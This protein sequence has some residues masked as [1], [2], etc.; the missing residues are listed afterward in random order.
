MHYYL[1]VRQMM[2]SL[3]VLD[4]I[5]DKA[6]RYAEARKFD[7]NN[8]CSARLF[9]DMLPF[10]AQIRIACDT[11]KATA[12][13]LSGKDVPRHEDNETTFAELRAR[14]GKCVAVLETFTADDF[15]RT[16]ATTMVRLPNKPGKA[17]AADEYL[18][19]RQIPNFYFHVVTA[20]D[21]LRHGGVEVGKND[22][23]GALEFVDA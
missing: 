3:R 13:N 17:I 10:T 20:Y 7:V 4:A 23:Y 11:A 15:A 12:G 6:T 18:F 8:F 22:F 14:I 5:L 16:T 1:V 19:A 21:L 9:P 2:R